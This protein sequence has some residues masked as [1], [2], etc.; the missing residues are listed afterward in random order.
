MESQLSTLSSLGGRTLD[1]PLCHEL[2]LILTH[3]DALPLYAA[4]PDRFAAAIAPDGATCVEWTALL[5]PLPVGRTLTCPPEPDPDAPERPI[6]L[7]YIESCKEAFRDVLDDAA[8]FYYLR[9]ASSFAGLRAAVIALT[10]LCGRSIIAELRVGDDE[11]NLTDGTAAVAA[12]GVLQRIGVTT[13]VLTAPDAPSLTEALDGIAPYARLSVGAAAPM[14]WMRAGLR[15]TNTELLLPVEEDMEAQLL[16]AAET[17]EVSVTPRDH[18]D[19]ILAPDGK[20]AHF[21]SPTI[22]IS[23]EIECGHRLEEALLEAEDEVGALKLVLEGE[24]DLVALE[25]HRY[26]ISRPICLCAESA[27]LLEAGL[28]VYPGLS[29]Y[30]GT[31]EQSEDVLH[32]LEQKYGLIRL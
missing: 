4:Q 21:I 16:Y 26:M 29:L 23:D 7:W 18:G 8:A 2:Q 12:V 13:V 25:E 30:D 11:G 15:L 6:T 17:A 10:D 32:Y 20:N 19:F 27:E 22:D 3:R 1:I 28:R 9:G 14:N 31:W 5:D 24:E